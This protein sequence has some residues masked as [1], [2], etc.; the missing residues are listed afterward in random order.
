VEHLPKIVRQ[1]LQTT[2]GQAAVHPD[3]DLLTAFVERSLGKRERLQVLEHLAQCGD[4]REVVSV[5]IPELESAHVIA[6]RRASSGWLRWPV[7]RWGALAVCVV[8]V[9]AAVTLPHFKRATE[10]PIA[11]SPTGPAVAAQKPAAEADS[12]LR[13]EIATNYKSQPQIQPKREIAAAPRPSK[14]LDE[15]EVIGKVT[16]TPLTKARSDKP[17]APPLSQVAA[18]APAPALP[19]KNADLERRKEE[20]AAVEGRTYGL[21]AANEV[22]TVE[23]KAATPAELA[24]VSPGKAKDE[25]QKLQDAKAGLARGTTTALMQKNLAYSSSSETDALLAGAKIVPR[26][27]LTSGGTLQRSLDAGKTWQPIPVAGKFAF[28]A[29]STVGLEI[30]VGGAAGTLYHSSDAGEHW[31]QVKPV[32]GGQLLTTDIIGVEF[33]DAQHG[34]LTT[35][36]HETWT[37]LDGGQSWDKR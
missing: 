10:A 19:S 14:K 27:T 3:A 9:G 29:L 11:A 25:S 7:L 15:S 16:T 32:A 8:V 1:R 23:A 18:A 31:Q 28:R 21:N 30:W 20:L 4:C 17:S 34:K 12:A 37:T 35:A 22:V 13:S 5:A 33:T 36:T 24:E 6:T 2:A 26:W